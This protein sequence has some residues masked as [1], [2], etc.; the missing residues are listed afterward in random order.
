MINFEFFKDLDL[1][2]EIISFFLHRKVPNKNLYWENKE[3]YINPTLGY[4]FIPIFCDCLMRLG[5]S[6]KEILSENHISSVE[7]ILN[8]A[9]KEEKQLISYQDHLKECSQIQERYSVK[10]HDYYTIDRFSKKNKK[11]LTDHQSLS[12]ANSYLYSINTLEIKNI[13]L[14]DVL[15]IWNSIVP[16][17]LIFDDIHDYS[18]DKEVNG[19][20]F[21]LESNSYAEAMI[22]SFNY[23]SESLDNLNDFNKK[24][25]SYISNEAAKIN[26]K[27]LVKIFSNAN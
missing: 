18:L 19:E 8:S 5:F 2:D 24:L 23:I 16:V 13:S 22:D 9:G 7:F 17:F 3:E 1:D 21:I 6:K 15:K 11:F 14:D 12:R 26:S 25:S 4:I 20:N 27:E 10:N